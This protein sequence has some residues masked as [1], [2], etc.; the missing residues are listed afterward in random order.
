VHGASNRRILVSNT[1]ALTSK[2]TASRAVDRAQ[3]SSRRPQ[4]EG[5]IGQQLAH[6]RA[7]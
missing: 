6:L 5:G 4:A 3:V 1:G 2:R 7:A